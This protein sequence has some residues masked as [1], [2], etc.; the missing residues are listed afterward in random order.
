MNKSRAFLWPLAAVLMVGL[1]TGASQAPILTFHFKDVNFPGAAGTSVYG[2]N[3]AGVIVA[4]F[5]ASNSITE[6]A[7]RSTIQ[8]AATRFAAT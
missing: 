6:K 7:P 5:M 2:I 8:M 3:D 4:S 1:A